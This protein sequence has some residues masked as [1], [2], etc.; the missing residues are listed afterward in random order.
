MFTPKQISALRYLIF[1]AK[2]GTELSKRVLAFLI[3]SSEGLTKDVCV[4]LV[5]DREGYTADEIVNAG[6]G[7]DNMNSCNSTTH[8]NQIL[9]V[10]GSE[11]TS[12]VHYGDFNPAPTGDPFNCDGIF[13]G[14]DRSSVIRPGLANVGMPL[15]YTFWLAKKKVL[16]TSNTCS[17]YSQRARKDRSKEARVVPNVGASLNLSRITDK[18]F[19][20]LSDARLFVY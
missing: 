20:T 15:R 6:Y 5:A 17:Y 2:D 19:R 18:K 11:L 12:S 10:M 13:A 8:L 7:F 3:E 14:Y 16:T 9:H 4:S 1:I